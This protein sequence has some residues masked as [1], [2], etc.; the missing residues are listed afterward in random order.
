MGVLED[1]FDYPMLSAMTAFKN[2]TEGYDISG[3]VNSTYLV[4]ARRN[5]CA[6]GDYQNLGVNGARVGAMNTTIQGGLS[7]APDSDQPVVLLYA[8]IGNDVCNG[9]NDTI[10]HMTTVESYTASVRATVEKLSKQLPKG[11]HVV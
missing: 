9:H 3:P 6:R 11:S 7:R 8:L 2:S 4:N 5:L 1:E 10:N